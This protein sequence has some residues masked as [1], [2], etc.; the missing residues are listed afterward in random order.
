[1]ADV[2][3]T[4]GHH[5]DMDTAATTPMTD[6][7]PSLR[8]PAQPGLPAGGLVLVEP[9]GSRLVD[10]HRAADRRLGASIGRCRPGI[11]R[12]S[13]ATVL[14]AA[15]HLAVMPR[16]RYRVHRW[17]LTDDAV[18]TR[19]GWLTQ[20]WRIAP[21]TRIQTVDSE[22][23][24]IGRLFHLTKVTV[25]TASA[26]GPLVIDG[27]DE[28]VAAE[29]ASEVTAAA[30]A[31]GATPHEQ[32]HGGPPDRRRRR[33]VRRGASNPGAGSPPGCCWSNPCAN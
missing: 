27:L 25:T 23:G 26:A 29:F 5:E 4:T 30:Q 8:P 9:G 17:E 22:R 33:T 31:S 18:Y 6:R 19:S 16:L 10:R 32:R 12:C 14:I 2:S 3:V 21:V 11:R 28:Q 7:E 1:M 24:P 13:T 15:V 20:E